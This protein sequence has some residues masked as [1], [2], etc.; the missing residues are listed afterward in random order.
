MWTRILQTEKNCEFD[1]VTPAELIA[2]K[3][4][5]LVGRLTR[6]YEPKKKIR[7][8]NM[9]IET[10]IDLINEYMYDWLND[11]NNSNDG[12]NVKHV[13][14][15]PQKRNMSEKSSYERNKK[16]DWIGGIG[17]V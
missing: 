8:S 9:T 11:S 17:L 12:R 14:E 16:C 4:L 3:F 6:D 7:K 13:Q 1:N 5:S 2:S 15:R 10:I